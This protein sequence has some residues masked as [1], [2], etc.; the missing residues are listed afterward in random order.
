MAISPWLFTALSVVLTAAA[1]LAFKLYATA[2][3]WGRLALTIGLFLLIPVST[4]MALREL[5]LAQVYL[6][7]AAVPV[8]SLVAAHLVLDETIRRSH[9]VS[10]AMIAVGIVVYQSAALTQ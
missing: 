10:T 8:L 1:H 6:C 3:G 9:L 2:G 5:T 4:F 7:T